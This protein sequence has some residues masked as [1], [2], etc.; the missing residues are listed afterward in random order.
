MKREC[1]GKIE[2]A[3]AMNLKEIKKGVTFEH[4]EHL[5]NK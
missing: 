3:R 2:A 5:L 1:K 4:N